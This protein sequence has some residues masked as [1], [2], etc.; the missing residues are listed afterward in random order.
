MPVHHCHRP[1]LLNK[2]PL[3]QAMKKCRQAWPP[4]ILMGFSQ[5]SPPESLVDEKLKLAKLFNIC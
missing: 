3:L 4:G 5:G 1:V 2:W